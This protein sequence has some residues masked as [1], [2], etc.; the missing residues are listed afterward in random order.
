M[1]CE[2]YL[3]KGVKKT[4]IAKKRQTNTRWPVLCVLSVV[5]VS[6]VW[7]PSS[8]VLTSPGSF[9]E[10]HVLGLFSRYTDG[11]TAVGPIICTLVSSTGDS[12]VST[13]RTTGLI[14]WLRVHPKRRKPF[15][16]F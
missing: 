11:E 3:N 8:V 10:M 15:F 9:F 7:S 5:E 12:D 1:V 2:L 13:C 6:K 16:K 14:H 4:K